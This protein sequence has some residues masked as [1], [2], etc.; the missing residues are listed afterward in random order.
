MGAAIATSTSAGQRPPPD[1]KSV[2]R[3]HMGQF[4][5]EIITLIALGDS[6]HPRE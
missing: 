5:D 6:R 2:R 4:V 3:K 1:I